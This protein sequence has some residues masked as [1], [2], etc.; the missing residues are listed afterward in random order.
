MTFHSCFWLIFFLFL[1]V[2]LFT[3][4]TRHNHNRDY[5]STAQFKFTIF[6]CCNKNFF[7]HKLLLATQ[8]WDKFFHFFHIKFFILL[9]VDSIQLYSLYWQKL[10][11]IF[12]MMMTADGCYW[13]L[14]CICSG[15]DGVSAVRVRCFALLFWNVHVS[16]IGLLDYWI[17]TGD[18][19]SDAQSHS[20]LLRDAR[21]W[22]TIRQTVSGI[23]VLASN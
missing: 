3:R 12:V 13:A 8:K 5:F 4:I 7:T 21:W 2:G 16:W 17:R 19:W 23:L 10:I 22:D 11:Y 20:S 9:C 6:F 15:M 18:L 14:N 1:F